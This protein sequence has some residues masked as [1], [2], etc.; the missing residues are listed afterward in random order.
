MNTDNRKFI[1]KQYEFAAHIRNPEQN[2]KPD[3]IEDR[4]MGIYRD[5]FYKNIEDFISSGF[6]VLRQLYDDEQ[7]HELV[8]DFIA[9]H[10]S[11]SPYFLEIA[12]EFLAYLQDEFTPRDCDPAF[13]LELA[14]YE[15]VELALTVSDESIRMDDIDANAD[16][17]EGHPVVSPLAWPLSYQWPVHELRPDYHPETAPNQATHIVVFRDRSDEVRFVL[18]NPI[19]ARLLYL[20]KENP[21]LSGLAAINQIAAELNHPN[22]ETVI[23]GGRQALEDLKAQGIILGTQQ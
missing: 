19:T 13:M 21:S 6:P 4:R 18:I 8:R 5:L 23:A 1:K 2:P 17:L 7:W 14:H 22:I 9:Q 12:E 16:L 11:R 10:R 20:L 15:W 3:G